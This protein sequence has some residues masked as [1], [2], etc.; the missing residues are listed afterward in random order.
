MVVSYR[1]GLC[2]ETICLKRLVVTY[3]LPHE[4]VTQSRTAA[5]AADV[6]T[7]KQF[8]NTIKCKQFI[9]LPL[10]FFPSYFPLCAAVQAVPG[11]YRMEATDFTGWKWFSLTMIMLAVV[12]FARK[13]TL[14]SRVLC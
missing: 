1:I 14:Q 11:T 5:D 3:C 7:L 10:Y 8:A 2:K 13:Q 6:D 12:I 4:T 9:T